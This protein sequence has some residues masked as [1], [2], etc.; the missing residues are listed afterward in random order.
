MSL[1]DKLK[2]RKP[3]E[4]TVTLDGDE[5]LVRF[6]G[7][8][9]KNKAFAAATVK[10]LLKPELLEPQLLAICVLDPATEQPVMP[11]PAD[12]DLPSD[13]GPLIRAVIQVCGMDKDEAKDMGKGSGEKDSSN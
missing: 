11:D 9:A 5:Y 7:R 8:M 1:R 10:A 12:W 3:A 2:Q 4:Q 6:P 13:V